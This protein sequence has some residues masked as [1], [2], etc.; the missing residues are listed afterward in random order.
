MAYGSVSGV[1]ALTGVE[2]TTEWDDRITAWLADSDAKIEKQLGQTFPDP[3]PAL[4]VR[5][6][7]LLTTLT[8]LDRMKAEGSLASFRVGDVSTDPLAAAEAARKNYEQEAN[9]ILRM[10]RSP[11]VKSSSYKYIEEED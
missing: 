2:E 5:L 1:R 6:S 10:Y 3:T 11:T 9:E 7:N 8:V 4:I